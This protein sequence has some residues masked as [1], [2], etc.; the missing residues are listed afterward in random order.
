MGAVAK[1]RQISAKLLLP[2]PLSTIPICVFLSLYWT[3]TAKNA[4]LLLT[5]CHYFLCLPVLIS[6]LSKMLLFSSLSAITFSVSLFLHLHCQNY[7]S[8]HHSPPFL[9]LSPCPYICTVEI[10]A[11]LTT[12]HH[13]FLYLPVLTSALSNCCSTPHFTTFLSL[14]PCPSICTV[15]LAAPSPLSTIP[16]Y[17]F[18]SLYLHCKIPA[19]P[20][21]PSQLPPF[22]SLPRCPLHLHCKNCC[23]PPY[24]SL[25]LPVLTSALSKL[26]LPS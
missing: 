3:C 25:C 17:A 22:L 21:P 11:S 16:F 7:C 2:S 5:L 13:S 12:L 14:S 15:K 1:L 10:A 8:P 6:A 19:P 18:L 24:S 26:L 9:S 4:A 23:S 20:P